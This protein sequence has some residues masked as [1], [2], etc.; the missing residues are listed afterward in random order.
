MS[1]NLE[2]NQEKELD[3]DEITEIEKSSYVKNHVLENISP[4]EVKRRYKFLSEIIF[5]K[6]IDHETYESLVEDIVVDDE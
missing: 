1:M 4:G 5:M 3:D 6:K 2:P